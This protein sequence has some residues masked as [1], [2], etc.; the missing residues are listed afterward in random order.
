MVFGAPL[1]NQTIVMD[2]DLSDIGPFS[3]GPQDLIRMGKATTDQI[4][5]T[6][7]KTSTNLEDLPQI[8]SYN[9]NIS[10]SPFWGDESICQIRIERVDFDLRQLGIEITPTSTFM[11]SLISGD[12][13]DPLKQSCR[14]SLDGG[15]LCSL[16]TGPGQIVAIRQTPILDEYDRPFL[17]Q[18]RLDNDGNVIDENGVWML[19]VP[20]NLDYLVTN[21][22]G[23]QIISPDPTIG[24][25]TSG[26]YRFKI[27]WKQSN[28]LGGDVRRAY[29]LV[30]NVRE[31]G[32]TSSTFDPLLDSLSTSDP[33]YVSAKASYYFGVD[34]TGY[35]TGNTVTIDQRITDAINNRNIPSEIR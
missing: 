24:I 21:E 10:V 35:T 17:E 23:E 31:H 20:M 34:W 13:D 2:M 27:K 8:V 15:D 22:F 7:F 19:E 16:I 4:S 30:P 32:W 1:G 29:F 3:L 28:E 33:N 14:P 25:P 9:E 11:G 18:Y 26:K 12:D 5:G 6:K